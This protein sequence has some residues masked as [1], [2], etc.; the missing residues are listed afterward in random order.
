MNIIHAGITTLTLLAMSTV[1]TV[2]MAAIPACEY[3]FDLVY[4]QAKANDIAIILVENLEPFLDVL[5]AAGLSIQKTT[6][7][8][9]VVTPDLIV[10]GLEQN[11]CLAPALEIDL[12]YQDALIEAASIIA[13]APTRGTSFYVRS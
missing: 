7:A 13:G 10:V 12:D 6:R 9:Y 4:A 5:E 8:F 1:S 3:I 11:T 2:S